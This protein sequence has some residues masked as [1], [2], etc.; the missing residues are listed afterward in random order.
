MRY[1]CILLQWPA[2]R[3]ALAIGQESS[4]GLLL[5]QLSCPLSG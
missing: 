2:N 1:D 3:M 5:L 4:L